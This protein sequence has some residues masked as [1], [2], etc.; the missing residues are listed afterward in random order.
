MKHSIRRNRNKQS[1]FVKSELNISTPP[2]LQIKKTHTHTNSWNSPGFYRGNILTSQFPIAISDYL[3]DLEAGIPRFCCSNFFPKAMSV[4]W[5]LKHLDSNSQQQSL[6]LLAR[7]FFSKHLSLGADPMRPIDRPL[8]INFGAITPSR[9]HPLGTTA[10]YPLL[11]GQ[12]VQHTHQRVC[13][14]AVR[15]HRRGGEFVFKQ[16]MINMEMTTHHPHWNPNVT[17]SKCNDSRKCIHKSSKI[18]ISWISH[19]WLEVYIQPSINIIHS[20]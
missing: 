7:H 20:F 11:R 15:H 3:D 8:K 2:T 14:S 10:D 19:T 18:R 6:Q 9:Y 1:L 4:V 16:K 13:P 5:N 12:R 17:E